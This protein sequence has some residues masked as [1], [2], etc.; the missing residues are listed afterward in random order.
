MKVLIMHHLEKIWDSAMQEHFGTSFHEQ[1]GNIVNHLEFNDYD[2]VILTR[3]ED[4]KLGEEHY[5]SGI[6]QY[7]D[8][9][10]EYAY[11]WQLSD[12]EEHYPDEKGVSWCDGGSHSEV[13]L[14]EDW[15]KDLSGDEVHIVGAFEGECIEDLEV[16]LNF[17]NVD[18]KKIPGLIV[19]GYG[20]YV[21]IFEK[22]KLNVRF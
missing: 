13:V 10:R 20:R 11:G 1:A 5:E 8:D 9:V 6:S 14:L 16:A 7:V 18:Y 19:G 2:K 3:F 17:L 15:V 22:K 12:Y 4:C 21:P